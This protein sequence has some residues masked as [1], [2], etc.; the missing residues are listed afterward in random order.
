MAGVLEIIADM[1][2]HDERRREAQRNRKRRSRDGHGTVTA[3]GRDIE[4]DA[5]PLPDKEKCPKE[6][7]PSPQSSEAIASG[8]VAPPNERAKVFTW[9]LDTVCRI[10]G[11]PPDPVRRLLGRW[12][13]AMNDDCRAL[14]RVIE[15]AVTANP[16]EPVSW[17]EGV[18]RSRSTGP[19]RNG[20]GGGFASIALELRNTDERRFDQPEPAH[21]AATA[22]QPGVVALPRY[23]AQRR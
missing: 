19:P 6:I 11:R 9:G 23:P 8:A 15:D 20:G 1:Q 17:I 13:K 22:D 5:A 4:R 10:T 2:D 14:N 3:Q 12:L 7:N 18:I 21:H 16:A